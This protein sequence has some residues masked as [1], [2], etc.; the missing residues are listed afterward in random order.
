MLSALVAASAISSAAAIRLEAA[1]VEGVR[2]QIVRVDTRSA[3]VRVGL[4]LAQGF[5]GGDESFSSMIQRSRPTV[6]INGAYFSKETRLPIGDIAVN[7][8]LMHSGRMGTVFTVGKDGLLDIQRVTRHKTY[9]WPDAKVAL[10]CGPA[11]V[12]DG[13]VE[14][15]WQAEGFRDPHV[16]GKAQRMALGYDQKGTLYFVHI[17]QGVSFETEAKIMKA[18]GC[19]EAMNL[20]AGASLA[21][22]ANGRN[23][24]S[25]GRKLTNVLA[26]WQTP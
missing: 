8:E 11:L 10:G 24:Q 6:A 13:K 12:L 23:L 22:Y 19:F 25:P 3:N 17:R 2:C 21:M 4:I 7:G 20:D 26:V 15:A 5:P 16:T 14:V 18:L 1:T 9:R